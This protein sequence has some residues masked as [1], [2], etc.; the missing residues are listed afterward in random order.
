M[1]FR[2]I[3]QLIVLI[4]RCN[5]KV[6]DLYEKSSINS[7]INLPNGKRYM[8]QKQ[9]NKTFADKLVVPNFTGCSTTS[10]DMVQGTINK[11]LSNNFIGSSLIDMEKEISLNYFSDG[12]VQTV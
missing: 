11:T 5:I 4:K 7:F 9:L 3:N 2:L 1:V 12:K 6:E 8:K 10:P